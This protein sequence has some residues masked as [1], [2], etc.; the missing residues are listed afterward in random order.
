[1][2][3]KGEIT[4]P[5]D[6]SLSHRALMFAAL[7]EGRSKIGNL[8]EGADVSSTISVLQQLGAEVAVKGNKLTLA[9]R[10]HRKLRTLTNSLYCG[11]SGTTLRL[12][13]GVLAG[14]GVQCTL[15]GDDS[16]NRR[17]VMRVI[18][19]LRL[20][21]AQIEA[22]GAGDHPP[23]TIN[24]RPLHGTTYSSPVASAQVKSAVL[25]AALHA[26][27][28][29]VYDEPTKSRD[30]TERFLVAQGVDF[31]I[32]GTRVRLSPGAILQPF[33]YTVPGDISTAAFYIVAALLAPRSE[34]T[35]KGVGLNPTRCGVLDILK[36]MGAQ[37]NVENRHEICGEPVGDLI[38]RSSTLS[39]I[40]TT[41]M[42]VATFID[43]VPILAVAALF[44]EGESRFAGLSELRVKESDRLQ[45][46]A[47]IVIAFGGDARI[48]G[49]D[50]L[51]TGSELTQARRP[52]VH[53]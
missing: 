22:S 42:N 53:G 33:D 34:V 27:G 23:V 21:G 43:E 41:G 48:D 20:M 51:I 9:G 45:G 30:H 47:D 4:L 5:G 50:L 13:M 17:P 3:L 49:D 29:T 15:S 31:E 44:A 39:A 26:D 8:S 32:E 52:A 24:G 36:L 1:M 2:A 7:A 12:M 10:G 35:I 37:F 16:L 19:P 40:D 25:L 11:N 28:E 6:K 38:V 46:I 18:E 14:S